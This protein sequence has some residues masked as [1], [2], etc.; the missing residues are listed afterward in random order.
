MNN[1]SFFSLVLVSGFGHP[2][3]FAARY[4]LAQAKAPFGYEMGGGNSEDICEFLGHDEGKMNQRGM[5]GPKE[6]FLATCVYFA[7]FYHEEILI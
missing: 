1:K 7:F 3:L 5:I 2:Y 6:G 4:I